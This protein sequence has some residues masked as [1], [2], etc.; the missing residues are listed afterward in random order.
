MSFLYNNIAAIAVALTA[1]V[2][3]WMFGGTRGALLVPVVPWFLLLLIE[4][5]FCFPQR[6]PG[7]S[8]YDARLR[9]WD[10]LK[11]DPITWIV[12]GFILILAIPFMNNGRCVVCDAAAIAQGLSAKPPVPMSP[13][14]VNRLDHLNVFLWFCAALPAMLVVKHSLIRSG[15]RIALD[16]IVWNGAALAVLGF[17]QSALEAPG[18]LWSTNGAAYWGVTDFFS[19]FGYP[20]MAGDYF[21]TLFG[22]SLALWRYD[23]EA[24]SEG[25]KKRDVSHLAAAPRQQ[26]WRK[27]SKLIPAAL[28]FFAAINTL[29]R[30]AIMLVSITACVYFIHTFVSFLSRMRKARRVWVGVWVLVGLGALLFFASNF[31]PERLNREVDTIDAKAVMDRVTGR[32]QYHARVANEI[33]RDYR[34][35][36]CGGWGYVHFC[37]P[38]MTREEYKNMQ[39][40]GGINVHNDY[41]QF[42]AEHGIVGFGALAAMVVLLL[43]PIFVSW[44]RMGKNL[45]FTKK[46]LPPKPMLIF[47]LPAP[48]FFILVTVVATLIHAFGDCPLRSPAV[49]TLFFVSLAALPGFMPHET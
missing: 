12:L 48:V 5:L 32:G 8:W 45:R 16:L 49:L 13:F 11:R 24:V 30:A 2:L 33:W 36:G 17:V 39:V 15:K 35:F 34:L 9:V 38:K 22:I 20:N 19:T 23:C 4:V 44:W 40:V 6:R 28:F 18:P 43:L 25:Y 41:L 1:S 29:S 31:A 37:I 10:G 21:T 7:E 27:H 47:V 14:C 26:F 46:N 42:L 3:A